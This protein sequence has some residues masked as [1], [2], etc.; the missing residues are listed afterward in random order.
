MSIK[1][2]F[3]ARDKNAQGGIFD[4]DM[5][6]NLDRTGFERKFK[7]NAVDRYATINSRPTLHLQADLA[8]KLTAT[9]PTFRQK[10]AVRR[11]F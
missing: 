4:Q 1:I 5:T 11:Y 3:V 7:R 6:A 10:N 2:P 8:R 9:R